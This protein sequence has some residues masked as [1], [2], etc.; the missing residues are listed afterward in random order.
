MK[1][2]KNFRLQIIIRILILFI[3]AL[4]FLL[5]WKETRLYAT[6]GILAILC[7]YQVFSLILF[8][9]K[10]NKNLN[11]FLT[12]VKHNDFSQSF[13]IK[14]LGSS[15]NELQDLFNQVMV[16][17][18]QT[19]SEKEEQYRYLQTIIQHVGIGLIVF[20]SNGDLQMINN[21]AKRLLR[22]RQLKNLKQMSH[23]D[24]NLGQTLLEL[25][26]G[27]RTLI[28]VQSAELELA[29]H[30]TK[31]FIRD[32]NYTLVSLQNIQS[33]LQEKEMEAWQIL[34]RVLTHE[35]MNSMTPITSMTATALD[36]LGSLDNHPQGEKERALTPE[37][38][39]DIGEALGTIHKRS[40][41]L[42]DFVGAYRNLTLIP[43][44]MF[45][46]FPL[47]E[48]F[49]RVNTLMAKK[50]RDN[51]VD[52][53]WQVNPETLELTADPALIEQLLINLILNS[54]EAFT[55]Q[56]E[57]SIDLLASLDENSRIQIQVK[58]NGPGID[59]QAQ[60]NIFIPFFTTKKN[61]SGI[62]L[63][64]S[65][66]IMRLHKGSIAVESDPDKMTLFTLRF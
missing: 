13:T 29:V 25:R 43:K 60:N 15:F 6:T 45:K 5:T 26:S 14:G 31:F 39:D 3:S 53:L 59:K 21:A 2:F 36:L 55:N 20:H 37:V 8:V 34:I 44:P 19:R 49:I 62:G 54:I 17:F 56:K 23:L 32:N 28:K 65:R 64:L 41:G 1:F 57:K 61:G 63:S 40:L 22:V 51:K 52:F 50:L 42:S 9:E 58:D 47:E 12:A 46:I 4:V 30:A 10:T 16:K 11:R 27:E 33:E 7:I 66:Q 24:E 35:I 18:Q 48:L 38:L